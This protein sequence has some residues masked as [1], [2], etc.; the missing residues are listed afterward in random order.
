MVRID[1]PGKPRR[2]R[3]V[4]GSIFG[5]KPRKTGPKIFSQTAFRYPGLSGL[6]SAAHASWI[7]S[8]PPILVELPLGAD[9]LAGYPKAVRRDF[10]GAAKW[11]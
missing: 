7:A 1:V 6:I 3:G 2:S 10:S 9:Q 5:L 11:P 8:G 4:P